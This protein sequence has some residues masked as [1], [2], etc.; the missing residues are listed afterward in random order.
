ME[1]SRGLHTL[2]CGLRGTNSVQTDHIRVF[3]LSCCRQQMVATEEQ[4]I[5]SGILYV[6]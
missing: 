3:T 5:T 4:Q 6:S 2:T 1:I